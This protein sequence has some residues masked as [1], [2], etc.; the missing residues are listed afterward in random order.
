MEEQEDTIVSS[1]DAID[2]ATQMA[3]E[4]PD[5]FT[6][7][8]LKTEPFAFGLPANVAKR[9][10]EYLA[11]KGVPDAIIGYVFNQ[12]CYAGAL[13]IHILRLGSAKLF[14]EYIEEQKAEKKL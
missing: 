5:E 12:I 11:T 6:M 4:D 13:S 3:K 9:T 10:S 2:W 1:D 7:R 8:L 14:K